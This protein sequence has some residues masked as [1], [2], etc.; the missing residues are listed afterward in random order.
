MILASFNLPFPPSV[1]GLFGG[2][3]GQK[4]FP[5]RQ[6][7]QWKDACPR[8]PRTNFD[9]VSIT[10]TFYFPDNRVR[11][12]ENYVKACSDHLV[13]YGVIRDD[14]WQCIREMHLIPGGIDK[15]N[16]RVEIVI[17]RIDG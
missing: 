17:A 6:Y 16:A 7:K 4:R 15:Y 2:G 5:S 8:L 3:S 13:K 14:C 10:Y 12:C 1:N 11:D 9:Q